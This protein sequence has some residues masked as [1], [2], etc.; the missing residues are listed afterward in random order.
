MEKVG[1][2]RVHADCDY[3][4][5]LYFEDEFDICLR[6]RERREKSIV[7]SF[8]FRKLDGR[9]VARGSLA[10]ACVRYDETLGRM[11]GVPIPDD[12]ASKIEAAAEVA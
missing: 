7:Y 4:A 11:R 3:T 2:P 8:V 9:D 5:P 12:V 10:V 1:W 6:V